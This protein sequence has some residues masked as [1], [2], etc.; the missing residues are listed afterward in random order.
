MLNRR[1]SKGNLDRIPALDETSTLKHILHN[2][3]VAAVILLV[4]A[5]LAFTIANTTIPIKGTPLGEWYAWLWHLDL[6]VSVH[7]FHIEKPVHLWINDGL[8]AIFFFVVGLEIKRELLV[9]ELASMRKAAL[10]I[11]AAIG[12]MVAPALVYAIINITMEGG[13]TIGWGIPMATDIAFAAGVLGLLSSRI[14][15]SLAVLL[16][17]LAIVDDLGSIIVIAVFYSESPQTEALFIGFSLILLS[18]LIARLGGRNPLVFIL[19]ALLVWIFF[20]KSGV[21]ATIAGVLLAFTVPVDARYDS[22]LFMRRIKKLLGRYEDGQKGLTARQ[23]TSRQQRTIRAIENECIH[24]EAPLQRIENK[25]HPYAALVIMP[26][27]A[28]ANSGVVVDFSSLGHL[29][30]QP[31]AL[32][33]IFGLLVGKQVG[34]MG[35]AWIVVKLG[36]AELPRG[37]TWKQVYGL[38]W[39]AG[40]GFTMSLFVGD[41]AF[42]GADAAHAPAGHAPAGHG[43]SGNAHLTEAKAATLV[44]SLIA[45][46]VGAVLLYKFTKPVPD[47]LED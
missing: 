30:M 10:P 16:L 40:I 47:H 37:V 32:G 9:G 33:V 1:K 45:G 7:T 5:V 20:L 29:L 38:C 18:F 21:H 19:I 41:L 14:P 22:P 2:D 46:V 3:A 35:A 36:M 25:L 24:V 15:S 42:S 39:L 34:I 4:T 31:V 23:L 11:A 6:G 28:F 27:F 44:T 26:I 43:A 8:M 12:G 17:A 13:S